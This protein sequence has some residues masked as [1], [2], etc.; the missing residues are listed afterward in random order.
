MFLYVRYRTY[1]KIQLDCVNN[2]GLSAL[3]AG[4]SMVAVLELLGMNGNVSLAEAERG[5]TG[6]IVCTAARVKNCKEMASML[7]ALR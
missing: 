5:V 1:K 3:Y 6:L 4:A 2:C 7:A